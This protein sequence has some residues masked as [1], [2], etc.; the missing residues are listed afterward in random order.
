VHIKKKDWNCGFESLVPLKNLLFM[1]PG[2]GLPCARG[3]KPYPLPEPHECVL[4]SHFFKMHCDFVLPSVPWS[5]K[6]LFLSKGKYDVY[7]LPCPFKLYASTSH[8]D[9]LIGLVICE[10]YRF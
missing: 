4:T 7:F 9:V 5:N 6:W 1:K 10:K 8:P 2:V 3:L